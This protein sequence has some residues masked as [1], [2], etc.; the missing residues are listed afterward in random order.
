M[1]ERGARLGADVDLPGIMANR[2]ALV[3][4]ALE[5][6]LPVQGERPPQVHEA[7]RYSVFAGGKR[8]RPL[9]VLLACE[10]V[11]GEPAD[12]LPAAA[13]LELIHTYSLI[14]DDLPAMDD[15][16]FR[17][18]R[19]TCHKVYGEAMAILAGDG[20]LT[21][22]FRVLA[23]PGAGRVPP[24]RRLQI[25]AEIAEAAGS[26]GMVG[27]Q[28]TDILS[29]GRAI[30]RETLLDLHARKT[31]ALIRVSIRAGGIAG[32]A[33]AGSLA[34]LTRYGEAVGLAFQ[35]VDDI[36]D[37]EGAT[38]EMG[39]TAGSDA[40]KHKATYPALFG[41]EPSRQDAARL[42]SEAKAALRP[43]GEKASPLAALADF[44]GN[45][46]H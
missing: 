14:H 4:A 38:E 6:W 32:G 18:G 29:E 20:L 43:L 27:G 23:D 10:A 21:E 12:A 11:G 36:L 8:L 39:K 31:G 26:L 45:R 19:P 25:I 24:A 15:D 7:M 1:A 30:D 5:R 13:A 2:R 42:L 17:R 3:D 35:I 40:R 46:R 34:A 37:I 22:A 28:A 44:V 41:L 16:D 33:D 9:L